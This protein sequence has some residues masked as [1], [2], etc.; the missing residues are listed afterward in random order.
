MDL[1]WSNVCNG[2]A[3]KQIKKPEIFVESIC[4]FRKIN[5]NSPQIGT[6]IRTACTFVSSPNKLSQRIDEVIVAL[7]SWVVL[8]MQALGG[9]V[10]SM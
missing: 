3:L 10:T 1:R 4:H 9:K 2:H 6:V 7:L 5:I 8:I